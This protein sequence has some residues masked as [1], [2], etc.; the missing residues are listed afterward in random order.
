MK[1][2]KSF[3]LSKKQR[4]AFLNCNGKINIFEGPVRAGKS[5]VSL[6]AFIEF[7]VSG[8]KGEAAICGYTEKTIKRNVIIPLQNLLGESMKYMSHKGELWIG[9]R[10]CHII[11]GNKEDSKNSL[12]GSTLACILIDEVVL[13]PE[14][15]FSMAITRISLKGAKIIAT[16]NPDSAHHWLKKNFIDRA[17][18]TGTKV[19]SFDIRDNPSNDESYIEFLSNQYSGVWKERMVYGKW[20]M[21]EGSVFPFFSES[22]HVID[23]TPKTAVEYVVGIDYGINNP[24]VFLLLGWDPNR[25]DYNF[26]VEKEY[27]FESKESG[28]SQKSDYELV[29]D[30]MAFISGKAIKAIYIDPSALSLKREMH[31][32][33]VK[34][35][36]SAKNDVL[37]GIRFLSQNLSENKLKISRRCPNT[38]KEICNYVWDQKASISGI[39]KPKKWLDHAV[40]AL[41]YVMYTRYFKKNE[42]PK[43]ADYWQEWERKYRWS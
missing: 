16:C 28:A 12:T 24:T 15:F 30:F 7:C 9:P 17:E 8:I 35:I 38:I 13:L 31:R 4:E 42:D 6:L 37:A 41:R 20:V 34:G 33:G 11:S 39:D 10:R 1:L 22:L 3:P 29:N 21:A 2:S 14:S 19:F 5:F 40:D 43:G 27:Y 26:W 36:F 18:E 32:Q 23:Q 25:K